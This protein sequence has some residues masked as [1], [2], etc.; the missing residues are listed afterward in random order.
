MR[1][2]VDEKTVKP[3]FFSDERGNL[4]FVSCIARYFFH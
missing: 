3:T 4:K 1:C 2:A